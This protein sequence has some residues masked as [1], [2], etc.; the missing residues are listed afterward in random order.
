MENSSSSTQE[1]EKPIIEKSI[2]REVRPPLSET[3][4]GIVWQLLSQ[5]VSHC[6]EFTFNQEG[7]FTALLKKLILQ[8]LGLH[9]LEGHANGPY[10]V[11]SWDTVRCCV[12]YDPPC[13]HRLDAAYTGLKPHVDGINPDIKIL[14]LRHDNL[15]SFAATTTATSSSSST[16]IPN[17]PSH[18]EKERVSEKERDSI[19]EP[20][21]SPK[22]QQQQ[23]SQPKEDILVD[24]HLELK[25][26]PLFG[27]KSFAKN[28]KPKELHADLRQVA[29]GSSDVAICVCS[30]GDFAKY[31]ASS[32][33]EKES[34]SEPKE[35]SDKLNNNEMASN[36]SSAFFAGVRTIDI[37]D[38]FT[39]VS[40]GPNTTSLARR[41]S[42]GGRSGGKGSVI[43]AVVMR[44]SVSFSP[45]LLALDSSRC[46]ISLHSSPLTTWRLRLTEF[47]TSS[48][49]DRTSASKIG[50]LSQE[51]VM[52]KIAC[53]ALEEL[54]A[55]AENGSVSN[56][57]LSSPVESPTKK[58]SPP[59][60]SKQLLNAPVLNATI[61]NSSSSST[62]TTI[63]NAKSGTSSP[64]NSPGKGKGRG[65]IASANAQ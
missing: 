51:E 61:G 47:L 9:I 45:S 55:V 46:L 29:D 58:S 5:L 57:K 12:S 33:R 2:R 19:A 10:Q 32:G 31:L 14:G 4:V 20:S 6:D 63:T 48:L 36:G 1:S 40:H 34:E 41:I 22:R 8:Q 56:S 43:V 15:S 52:E 62:T 27:S 30:V 49:S 65:G 26:I 18:R 54:N 53:L 23:L 21:T 59:S 50:V 16:D 64:K 37:Q 42:P 11:L 60:A 13:R 25:C 39:V 24:L 17:S 28:V 38:Y 35:T 3:E 7:A 44:N